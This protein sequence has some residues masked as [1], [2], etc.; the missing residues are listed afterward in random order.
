MGAVENTLIILLVVLA[1]GLIVPELFLRLKIPYVTTLILIG[2][3]L[4]PH[5]IGYVGSNEVIEFFGFLGFTFLMLLAG[6]ETNLDVLKKSKL[7]IGKMALGGGLLPLIAGFLIVKFFGLSTIEALLVGTVFVSSSVAIIIPTIRA[8]GIFGK[9]EGQMMVAAVVIQD[10]V[11]LFLMAIVFQTIDPITTL[12]LPLYFIV[13]FVS[14]FAMKTFIP[15]LSSWFLTKGHLF[16]HEAHEDET[17]FIIILLIATLVYFSYLGVHPIVAA[18]LVGILLSGTVKSDK[19]FLKLHTLGYGLFVPVF[20][21]IAGMRMDLKIFLNFDTTNIFIFALITTFLVSKVAGGF[22]GA[23][24]AGLSVIDS[25][26]FGIVSTPQ[27]TTTLAVTYAASSAGLLST[28]VTTGIIALAVI[29]TV[30]APTFLKFHA[31]KFGMKMM[32]HR[33]VP[34]YAKKLDS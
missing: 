2:A 32:P 20:F 5:G 21:F 26:F 1:S 17:R 7:G 8:A 12:P 16:K 23:R 28:S 25:E 34:K 27:L 15:K 11:S 31:E 9:P 30:L 14:V 29:T 10:I 4:G 13:L 19:I 18:F 24:L 3:V 22:I 6:M 33:A